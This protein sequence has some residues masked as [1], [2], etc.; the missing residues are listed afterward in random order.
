VCI[1]VLLL[2]YVHRQRIFIP[3]VCLGRLHSIYHMYKEKMRQYSGQFL[4]LTFTWSTVGARHHR[5]QHGPPP[6]TKESGDIIRSKS[7]FFTRQAHRYRKTMQVMR[8]DGCWI[9]VLCLVGCE[10]GCPRPCHHFF[11]FS[12]FPFHLPL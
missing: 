4:Q 7:F 11:R 1:N 12:C 10:T 2:I 6:Y 9:D 3:S 8:I 5:Q